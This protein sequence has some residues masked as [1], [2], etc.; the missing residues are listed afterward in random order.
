MPGIVILAVFVILL[1]P[2]GRPAVAPLAAGG[3]GRRRGPGRS[4]AILAVGYWPLRG[5]QLVTQEG[6]VPPWSA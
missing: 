5:P 3:L 6:S 1:F 4:A 2:D